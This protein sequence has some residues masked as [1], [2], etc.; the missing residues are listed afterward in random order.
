MI[1]S[2]LREAQRVLSCFCEEKSSVRQIAQAAEAMYRS[3]QSGGK[4]LC[5]GN[6][7]SHCDA[8]HFA[9]EL[10]GRFRKDRPP[11]PALAISDSAHLTCV[12][13]DYG[14]KYV[15]SR[16]VDA[17][18][19]PEDILFAVSTSGNSENIC[20][21]LLSARARKMCSILLTGKDG[22]ASKDLADIEIHVPYEGYS[23]RIQ[24][25][26]I[27]IIH[28][29]VYLLEKKLYKNGSF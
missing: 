18:A 9:E 2:E 15:F 26:H 14:F 8:S 20:Q 10:S 28:I 24:E 1:L 21:A 25:M 4:I 27:K 7:G 22:G 5:C 16:C 11:L 23:D 12:A 19:G 17:L 13:N 3:I 6:G 29:I